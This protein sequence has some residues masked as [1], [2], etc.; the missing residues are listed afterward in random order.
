MHTI[1]YEAFVSQFS[2]D[3][4]KQQFCADFDQGL[5]VCS[6]ICDRYAADSSR[7]ALR[8]QRIDGSSGEMTFAELQRRA[9]RFAGFLKVQGIGPGDRVACLL[10]RTPELLI[11]V[12]GTLKVGAVYQPLFTAFGS[13]AIE[14]R[15]E[16]AQSKLIITN[17]EQWPKL[18]DV[19]GLPRTMLVADSA[20][21]VKGMDSEKGSPDF[22]FAAELDKQSDCFEPVLIGADDPML[23]MFTSGT[24]GKAKG[25]VVPARALMAFHMYMKYAVGLR[26]DDKFWNVADP[27]WAYGLYYGII[28]PLQLGATIHFNEAGFTADNTFEFLRKYAITNLAAAPTAYRLLKA[29]DDL[30]KYYPD[31]NLR[32]ASSAGEPLNP[33]I[34]SW[35]QRMLNCRV[36]DQYGQTETGMTSANFHEL[37]H[38]HRDAS[39]GY[40]IPGYRLVALDPYG[41]EVAPGESGELAV[42]MSNS[43]L[44]FFQGYMGDAKKPYKDQYY[45]TGDVVV[46]NGDGSHSYSGRDDDIIASAGYRIG[47]AEVESALLEHPAVIESAVVGK[48]DAERGAI[49]K[50]YVVV[51]PEYY[52]DDALAKELQQ[53]VRKC[54][55]THSFPREIEFVDEL[56]KTSS[57]K[58]QRFMLRKQAENEVNS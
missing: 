1:S 21:A 26:A 15:L 18:A 17:P 58:I 2:M 13:G 24:T 42:D 37:E 14:Y 36:C 31:I 39:M 23:Q 35:A 12:L 43:P 16:Q 20:D 28:A 8:Y 38:L 10:P 56:P 49:V 51:R 33:E 44:F 48:P 41:N 53:H 3:S 11:C 54:L 30:L 9:A 4:L 32:V 40:P 5:N 22:L 57:G 7:V 6:E 25:L 29:N 27:G 46:S 19:K 55:S 34:V 52:R 47:P 50:A 45:L